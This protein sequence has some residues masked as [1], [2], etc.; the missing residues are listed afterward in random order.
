M[1]PDFTHYIVDENGKGVGQARIRFR[2][3]NQTYCEYREGDA[4][5]T[6]FGAIANKRLV[7]IDIWEYLLKQRV[8]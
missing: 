2:H 8:P 5:E 6:K 4:Q 1:P 3:K 7:P